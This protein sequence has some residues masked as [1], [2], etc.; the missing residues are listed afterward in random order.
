MS[1]FNVLIYFLK[2]KKILCFLI[3]NFFFVFNVV[4]FVLV[5]T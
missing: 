3:F 5:K 2:L 4:F 1:F